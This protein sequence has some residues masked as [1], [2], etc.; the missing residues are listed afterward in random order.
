[1]V[2]LLIP[3]VV[4]FGDTKLLTTVEQKIEHQISYKCA[5]IKEKT[6][7]K[8]PKTEWKFLCI[9][10]KFPDRS[11]ATSVWSSYS[12]PERTG[13]PQILKCFKVNRQFL[14]ILG[15]RFVLS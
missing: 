8:S 2:T 4:F 1:M 7:D 5:Y 11:T 15:S 10:A 13:A 9:V 3:V 6:K 14:L 12:T